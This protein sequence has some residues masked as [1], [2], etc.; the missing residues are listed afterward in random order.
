MFEF[1]IVEFR[2]MFPQ[3][4]DGEKFPL[5]W[6]ELQLDLALCYI[7]SDYYGRLTGDCRKRAIYLMLAHL[8]YI[9]AQINGPGGS[10]DSAG[11]QTGIVTSSTIGSVSVGLAQPPFGS[12][13]FKYWMNQSPY[14]SMLLAL[15]KARSTGGFYI[16]GSDSRSAIRFNRGY[17]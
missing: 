11:G 13:A 3:F 10:A 4:T 6:I 1:S 17:W 16:G 15:L 12:D 14:G 9:N 5:A 7:S 2:A 8:L